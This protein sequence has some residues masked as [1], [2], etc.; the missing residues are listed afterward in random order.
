MSGQ[1]PNCGREPGPGMLWEDGQL[2][3]IG[4]ALILGCQGVLHLA[5]MWSAPPL[6]VGCIGDFWLSQLSQ[7]GLNLLDDLRQVIFLLLVLEPSLV[8]ERVELGKYEV[9]VQRLHF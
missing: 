2:L 7:Y 1:S 9:P 6:S 5:M 4:T 8:S 3:V